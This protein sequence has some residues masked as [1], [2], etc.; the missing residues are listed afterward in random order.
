MMTILDDSYH[1]G[2]VTI[3]DWAIFRTM[4]ASVGRRQPSVPRPSVKERSFSEVTV[5]RTSEGLR[6]V[7]PPVAKLQH[8]WGHQWPNGSSRHFV[9]P[10]LCRAAG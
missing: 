2:T 5:R 9:P 10:E 8:R 1:T 4:A 3:R 6:S 7:V